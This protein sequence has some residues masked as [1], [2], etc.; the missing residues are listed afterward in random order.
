MTSGLV[1]F[2]GNVKNEVPIEDWLDDFDCRCTWMERTYSKDERM[3]VR[4]KALR[5]K[6][7]GLARLF[8]DEQPTEVREDWWMAAGALTNRFKRLPLEIRQRHAMNHWRLMKQRN[9]SLKEYITRVYEIYDDILDTPYWNNRVAKRMVYGLC[10]VDFSEA[11]RKAL[12]D[13]DYTLDQA[14]EIIWTLAKDK[15]DKEMEMN[16]VS[17]SPEQATT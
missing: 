2:H 14:S 17:K 1:P 16:E 5:S 12:V 3:T 13:E 6:L 10:D 9:M 8:F 11:V 4:M 7:A 15:E